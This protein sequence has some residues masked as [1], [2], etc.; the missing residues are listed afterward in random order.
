MAKRRS[1]KIDDFGQFI[2]G[3]FKY[4]GALTYDEFEKMTEAEQRL[5][6]KRDVIWP[7]IDA[8]Q[9][10]ADGEDNFL[11]YV[12]TRIRRFTYAVPKA[13]NNDFVER[14]KNY[15]KSLTELRDAVMALKTENELYTFARNVRGLHPEWDACVETYK[16]YS[17]SWNM[18]S[19]RNRCIELNFPYN[20]KK[21]S[22]ERKQA[23][24][25]SP[26]DKIEREGPDYRK[27]KN[28]T[29]RK[30]ENT[31]SFRGVVFGASVPQKERQD[32]LNYGYDGLMDLAVGLNIANSDVS[33]GGRL[34]ISFAARGRGFSGT[35][36]H[37]EVLA[38]VIN[39]TRLRGAGTF[40]KLWFH[41]MDDLLAKFCGITSGHLAS[42]ADDDE[43][44][45][46]PKSFNALITALKVDD[47]GNETSFYQGSAKFD[48]HF[49]KNAYG[50]WNANSEMVARAFACYLKDCIGCKS[51]YIIAHADSFHWEHENEA[52]YAIPQGEERDLFNG[53]FDILFNDLRKIGFFHERPIEMPS[54]PVAQSKVSGMPQTVSTSN[55]ENENISGKQISLF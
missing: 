13:H 47:E 55:D 22:S 28:S 15:V 26:L 41:A 32:D 40:A 27:S 33:L 21:K 50:G 54:Q 20:N 46:L 16:I 44:K 43:K 6:A 35:G 51:D 48:K 38:E 52:L 5:R 36:G 7:N 11:V 4:H 3:C 2:P 9:L 45:K 18:N 23:F 12:K 29:E 24:K 1:K 49:R 14:A 19:M 53:M 34:N 31:F 39:M 17:I 37:Y 10:V 42:Q 8:L 25:L 30:W